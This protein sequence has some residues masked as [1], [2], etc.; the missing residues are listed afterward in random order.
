[1][2][3][4]FLVSGLLV[5]P[6][7]EFQIGILEASFLC[8]LASSVL[9]KSD[10]VMVPKL[11]QGLGFKKF[12]VSVWLVFSVLQ[13]CLGLGLYLSGELVDPLNQDTQPGFW[14]TSLYLIIAFPL[15]SVF[16]IS[17]EFLLFVS[18][19][20]ISKFLLFLCQSVLYICIILSERCP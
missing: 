11:L 7:I 14:Q 16:S 13:I 6:S 15:F 5:W 1:M 4:T 12:K 18:A 19:A 10:A 17:L 20:E 2:L 9:Q 3:F 8:L